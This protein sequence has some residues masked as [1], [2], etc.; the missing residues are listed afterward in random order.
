L[1]PAIVPSRS[2]TTA[3]TGNYS[4]FGPA[5][6]EGLKHFLRKIYF[7]VTVSFIEDSL[8][9]THMNLKQHF[10]SQA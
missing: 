7:V 1:K 10:A 2:K 5:D 8:S 6:F 9:G 4:H 3:L